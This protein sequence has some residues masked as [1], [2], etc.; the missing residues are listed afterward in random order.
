MSQSEPEPELP[1]IPTID[2]RGAPALGI[3]AAADATPD[4]QPATRADGWLAFPR[5]YWVLWGGMLINRL[6][7][8]EGLANVTFT[9]SNGTANAPA[10]YTDSDQVL[11]FA[12]GVTSQTATIPINNDDFFE[13]NETILLALASPTGGALLG[14]RRAVQAGT[15]LCA[16]TV[17]GP[18]SR[19]RPLT[20]R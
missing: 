6:G 16:G 8:S 7:G 15:V 19:R 20:G 12:S 9:T 18:G 13:G 10:D 2:A 17:T 3:A 4:D 5:T 1:R 14:D 11:V